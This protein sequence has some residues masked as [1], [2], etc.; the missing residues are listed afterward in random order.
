MRYLFA[1]V[2]VSG[3]DKGKRLELKDK[4]AF[5]IGTDRAC[6][7]VLSGVQMPGQL[8]LSR[9][10]DGSVWLENGSSLNSIYL[11]D[12]PLGSPSM[13]SPGD[14]IRVNDTIIKFYS[15]G[16][17]GHASGIT[18][19]PVSVHKQTQYIGSDNITIGRDPSNT[20]VLNHPLVSRKHARIAREDG[21][22]VIYD[23][24][25][26][27]GT[28][29]DGISVTKKMNLPP[30][31]LIGVAGCR[32]LFEQ[33]RLTEYDGNLSPYL[34]AAVLAKVRSYLS[35][36]QKW[37]DQQYMNTGGYPV[38][39]VDMP[40]VSPPT[41]SNFLVIW[42]ALTNSRIAR[43]YMSQLPQ[44]PELT[45][46]SAQSIPSPYSGKATELVRALFKRNGKVVEG[47]FTTTVIETVPFAH[48]PGGHQGY[49]VMFMGVTAP[50][51][52]F[53]AIQD[54]LIQSL[55]SFNLSERYVQNYIE[56]SRESFGGVLRA[57]QTLRE[58]SDIIIKGWTEWQKT[59]DILS[60][61]LK[62][63]HVRQGKS[64]GPLH[65][66]SV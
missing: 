31:A 40:V 54:T 60:A 51:R 59:Y 61:K 62:R 1:L 39:W 50:Q 38:P 37:I 7:M 57:G 46:I 64:K 20:I 53:M 66:Y 4:I 14:T 34:A 27:N 10:S 12:S 3:P 16:I 28:Y 56:S 9:K 26:T 32:F 2:I 35:Q 18:Y 13:L 17:A 22:Y 63:R 24:N 48:G 42:N 52:E 55:T 65:Q 6:D 44:F 41:A 11:N 23:L 36:Q 21:G 45:I 29:V 49:A 19:E 8:F 33:G 5:S 43:G 25:S 15:V 58:T 47:L 30:S